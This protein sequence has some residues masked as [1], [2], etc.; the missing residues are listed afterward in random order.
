MEIVACGWP[1]MRGVSQLVQASL[2]PLNRLGN[3]V[4]V[5]YFEF[6]ISSCSVISVSLGR[7]GYYLLAFLCYVM[8]VHSWSS[9]G[10]QSSSYASAFAP[11]VGGV[12]KV[13]S[14]ED[15]TACNTIDREAYLQPSM[16]FPLLVMRLRYSI[17][18]LRYLIWF[19]DELHLVAAEFWNSIWKFGGGW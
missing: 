7:A 2:F 13:N 11:V 19:M 8:L 1:V 9:S 6:S 4:R 15:S 5:F 17:Y 12:W 14:P 18:N 3:P 10:W 16:C